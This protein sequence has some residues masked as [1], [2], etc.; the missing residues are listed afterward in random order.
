MGARFEALIGRGRSYGTLGFQVH[1]GW[2]QFDLCLSVTSS[3]LLSESLDRQISMTVG[4]IHG[5][6]QL[7]AA[8]HLVR[9]GVVLVVGVPQIPLPRVRHS[10]TLVTAL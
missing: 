5:N 10:A 2:I 8:A 6:V 9:R 4:V 7:G 3:I 1:S